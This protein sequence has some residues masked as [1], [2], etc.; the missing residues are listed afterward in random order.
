MEKLLQTYLLVSISVLC[1]MSLWF[2]VSLLKKR[3]DVAD[4]AWGL[5]FLLIA[6]ITFLKEGF[7][8]GKPFL[9]T[10]LVLFWSLRLSLHIYFRNKGKKED[11][12]YEKWRSEWGRWFYI[13]SFFQV[14]FLQGVLMILV[15]S[16]IIFINTFRS[17]LVFLDFF[18][19]LIWMIGFFFESVG[20][21]QLLKFIKSKKGGIM[22]SGLWRYTRH[23][24]YFGE[25]AQWWGIWLIA[26]S[27]PYGWVSVIGPLLITFLILK[28]SG[29]PLLEKKMEENIDFKEYKKST[30]IFFPLPPKK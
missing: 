3:N 4:I 8:F 29:I 25:V 12:R 24:N 15:S 17:E 13:R 26:L 14:F 1:Y 2:F 5:G 20:D 11:Y 10:L 18:G 19:V 30:S 22:K 9:V 27:V 7:A 21:F 23:P 28:V 16:P 6:M